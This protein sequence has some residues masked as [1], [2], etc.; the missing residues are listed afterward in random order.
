[1]RS[2]VFLFPVKA[3][4]FHCHR[5]VTERQFC[6]AKINECEDSDAFN[7][8]CSVETWSS[9]SDCSVTCGSGIRSRERKLQNPDQSSQC[10]VELT[11]RERC[12][13]ESFKLIIH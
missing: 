10:K 7:S 6:N 1:M 5:Q 12:I 13:G 8:K 2:R 11:N 3:Q 9:W 4:M